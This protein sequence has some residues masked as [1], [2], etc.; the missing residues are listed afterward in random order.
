MENHRPIRPFRALFPARSPAGDF[1]A[2]C[3][4]VLARSVTE[5]RLSGKAL[6]QLPKKRARRGRAIPEPRSRRLRNHA[7]VIPLPR[8]D[9]LR[10]RGRLPSV[11][12]LKPRKT[13]PPF[14]GAD[15]GQ[16]GRGAGG[17]GGDRRFLHLRRSLGQPQG[18]HG[19]DG[20]SALHA[21]DAPGPAHP[22]L[23]PRR[24]DDR[25]DALGQGAGD[26]PR[27]GRADLLR[28]PADG[29]LERG[30]ADQPRAPPQGARPP[31]RHQPRGLGRRLPPPARGPGKVVGDPHRHQHRDRR[32]RVRRGASG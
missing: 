2:P 32:R 23:R 15:H 5:E 22:A 1:F 6:Y 7:R 10:G 24:G 18:R 9:P 21:G 16:R 25:G 20:A 31:A 12:S 19:V 30:P 13:G 14:H 3:Y 11:A 4:F 28:Q 8:K 17:P 29:G 27:Q 26:D